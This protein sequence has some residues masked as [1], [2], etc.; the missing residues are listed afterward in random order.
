[1]TGELVFML[2][3]TAVSCLVVGVAGLLLLHL[4][5]HRSV[6]YS[7]V[8]C[9]L[10][11]VAAVVVAVQVNVRAMFLSEHDAEVITVVLSA[12]AVPAVLIALVVGR[13]LAAGTRTLAA[14]LNRLVDAG[15]ASGAAADGRPVSAEM[16]E[17]TE[18][19][20]EIRKRLEASRTR[21]AALEESRRAL[22]A[23]M[24]HD[25][26]TP[27]AGV[28][29]LAE[30]LEDGVVPDVPGALRQMRASVDRIARMVDSLFEL[31]RL[32]ARPPGERATA[33]VS[34]RE[35]AED[36]VAEARPAAAA[37]NVRLD[38]DIDGRLPVRGDGDELARA[39]SNLVA[40]AVRYT[41]PGHD[42]RV[43]GGERDGRVELAVADGCGGIPEPELGR[44]FEVGW[45]GAAQPP[46]DDAVSAGMGLAIVRGVVESHGGEVSASNRDGGC[47]FAVVLPAGP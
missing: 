22:V 15:D 41:A 31:S 28:R 46:D 37:R 35:V 30:G 36:V 38:V 43:T 34:L 42:V 33:L 27:L 25:L 19:L 47:S 23:S 44:V 3:A 18:R 7:L 10:I 21:E 4:L 16:S 5:R 29:A 14:R 1:M 8:V 11:P 12:A 17:L 32:Q 2:T 39:L 9:A 13:R 20:E 45:R 40:N 24:S 26:R 6:V